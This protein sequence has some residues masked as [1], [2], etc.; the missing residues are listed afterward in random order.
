MQTSG[1]VLKVQ[2]LVSACYPTLV[3]PALVDSVRVYAKVYQGKVGKRALAF[4]LWDTAFQRLTDTG[5]CQI[6]VNCSG[7]MTGFWNRFVLCTKRSP[8]LSP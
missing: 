7:P 6:S 8:V 5:V 1:S 2:Q 4:R 3:V